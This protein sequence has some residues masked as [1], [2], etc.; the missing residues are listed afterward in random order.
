MDNYYRDIVENLYDCVY[1]VDRD[2]RITFW[3]KAAEQLTGY[4]RDEVIGK[5]CFDN[6]LRHTDEQGNFLCEEGCPLAGTIADGRIREKEIYLHHK[7]GHRVPVAVRVNP[8]H[9]E[10]GEILGAVELFSDRSPNLAIKEK[11]KELEN[12]CLMDCLTSLANRRYIEISIVEKLNEIRRYNWPSGILFMDIDHFKDVNDR[13]GHDV[14]DEILKTVAKT[15]VSNSRPFDVFGRWG[16]EEFVGIIRNITERNLYA[17]ADKFRL[18]VRNSDVKTD[19]G[20]TVSVTISIG[21]TM[22]N[23][24]D[25]LDSVI[26]RADQLMYASKSAGRNKTTADS[27]DYPKPNS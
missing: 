6:I 8:V 13:Y 22:L 4:G 2:R 17:I 12:L 1:F 21:A 11:M 9:T 27:Q 5:K 16:G 14:G 18:L 25:T 19:E 10:A 15:F 20:D 23:R 3:N 26:K 24:D 7:E